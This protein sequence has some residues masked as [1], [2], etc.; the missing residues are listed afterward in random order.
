M[1][2]SGKPCDEGLTII[3]LLT[4]PAEKARTEKMTSVTDLRENGSDYLIKPNKM[5]I[6]WF[7]KSGG[8]GIMPE[9]KFRVELRELLVKQPTCSMRRE[10]WPGVRRRTLLWRRWSRQTASCPG[11]RL[12]TPQSRTGRSY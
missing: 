2:S 7:D 9:I 6:H 5:C 1:L 3:R 4:S 11:V 10:G 12:G 8:C